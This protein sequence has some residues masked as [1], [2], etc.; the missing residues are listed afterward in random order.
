MSDEASGTNGT[1]GTS[2]GVD[3]TLAPKKLD[4][5]AKRRDMLLFDP[6]DVLI[7]ADKAHPLYDESADW[8]I[9][10]GFVANIMEL[11][12]L[13]PV[14]IRAERKE[15]GSPL[16]EVVAGRSRTL[17]CREANKR[18]KK[19]HKEPK[20]LP[21]IVRKGDDALLLAELAAENGF[22]RKRSLIAKAEHMQK[23]LDL[24]RNKA[25]LQLIFN[26][27]APAVGYHLKL[28]KLAPSVK[29]AVEAGKITAVLAAKELAEL[30]PGEQVSALGKLLESGVTK[31]EGAKAAV[32]A[33]KDEKK[34]GKKAEIDK[35]KKRLRGRPVME[36]WSKGLKKAEGRDVLVARAVLSYLFG[37]DRALSGYPRLAE[38][39]GEE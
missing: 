39:L 17:H 29:K 23:L 5:G 24:G 21:A 20:L 27:S 36:R 25:Y 15:D 18:L 7:P 31:G 10:E 14:L 33:I 2:N 19:A 13:E 28:L 35:T 4:F 9:D 22:R 34:T 30:E 11:G 12:V 3:K 38:A 16:A 26:M 37:N 8:P 6:E 32:R 1:N